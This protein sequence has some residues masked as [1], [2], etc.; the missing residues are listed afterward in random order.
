MDESAVELPRALQLMWGIEGPARPG[1]KPTLH[2]SDIGA[3]AVKLADTAGLGAVSMAKV[4]AEVGFTTMSLYRYVD[5][6][7]ELY[8]V[9]LD[10]AFGLPDPIDPELDWRA[11][12]T[13]WAIMS[14]DAMHRHPWIL[15][16]PLFEPP[17]SPKQLVWMEAGL[18]TLS[19]T[20]LS[21]ADQLQSMVL[22]NIFVRGAAQLTADMFVSPERSKEANDQL[23]AQR[24]MMLA[25]P[26]RFPMI[27]ATIGGGGLEDGDG[28]F[29]GDDFHFGLTAVLDGIQALI[30]RSTPATR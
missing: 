16:V 6:K 23:Y 27:A 12:I 4:A 5:S 21:A 28:D 26:D 1:P 19:G 3:A 9:M 11:G 24:L 8:T 15:Q 29:D 25:T 13:Q 14:R 18:Q 20:A 10:E 17:L 22:V 30:D 7:D 2:I